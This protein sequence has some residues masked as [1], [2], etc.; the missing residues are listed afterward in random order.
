MTRRQGTLGFTEVY[1]GTD[2]TEEAV[3]PAQQFTAAGSRRTP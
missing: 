2:S 3:L 1:R